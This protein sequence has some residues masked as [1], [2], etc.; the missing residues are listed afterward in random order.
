MRTLL[1]A[2]AAAFGAAVA[3]PAFAQNA[4]PTPPPATTGTP[5]MSPS[6]ADAAPDQY[7]QKAQQA[8]QHHRS[9]DARDALERAETRLLD[10]STLASAAD[11]PDTAPAIHDISQAIDS[12][13]HHDWKAASQNIEAAMHDSQMAQSS[14]GGMPGQAAGMSQMPAG[15]MP[16]TTTSG[17]AMSA[18]PASVPMGGVLPPA[19]GVQAPSGGVMP[20]STQ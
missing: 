6:G 11:Q 14:G 20:P 19:G 15:Q 8:V 9:R 5:D 3:V 7:L 16:A 18:A 17:G 1:L 10:R 13:N 12:L 2:S 4:A